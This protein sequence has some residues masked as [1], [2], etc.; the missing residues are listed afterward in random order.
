MLI[1]WSPDPPPVLG[2]WRYSIRRPVRCPSQASTV[3]RAVGERLHL[4]PS[5]LPD[6]GLEAVPRAHHPIFIP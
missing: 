6:Q 2:S 5:D 3:C 1:P 4:V